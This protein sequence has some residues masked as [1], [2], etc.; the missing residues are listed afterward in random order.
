MP[1]STIAQTEPIPL[2]RVAVVRPFTDFLEDIGAPVTR[3]LRQAGLPYHALE[4]VDNYIPS[5][6]FWSFL[7]NM[8]RSEGMEE[9]GYY[10]G[11]RF[12]AD[13]ADPHMADLLRRSPTLYQGILKASALVNRTV[14]NCRWG[15]VQP[16]NRGYQR[17]YHR[18]SCKADNPAIEQIGW[19]GIMTLIGCVHVFTG[20]RWQPA[21]IGIMSDQAPCRYIRDRFSRT[22]MRL[23]QPYSYIA[24]DNALLTLPP[25]PVKTA[26]PVSSPPCN[27]FVAEDF[28]GSLQ[29]ALL[30]YLQNGDL[31][32]EIAAGLC[33]MSK[34]TLQRKLTELGTSYTEVLNHARFR[35]ASRMLQDP[36]MRVTD[37][38]HRLGY[39]DVA[40][41]SRAFRR[42]AG[43]S[44]SEYLQY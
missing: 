17:F 5:H 14:T 43:V 34:R 10:V 23:S 41:F 3:G 7:I 26:I 36:G 2:H 38:A 1:N 44:P 16:R 12:A 25:L 11:Q 28:A 9:L 15:I 24:L 29:Q 40:H 8:S 19:F 13:S 39:S 35:V 4:S 21:E 27:E 30:A 6:R 37:V 18:P 20:P 32:I 31:N 33:N 22:R 42:I